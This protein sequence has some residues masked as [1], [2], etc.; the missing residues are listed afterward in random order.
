ML[1]LAAHDDD[2]ATQMMRLVVIHSIVAGVVEIGEGLPHRM[3]W[4][5][6]AWVQDE[7]AEAMIGARDSC[8]QTWT[9]QLVVLENV[10]VL[11]L[12]VAMMV[13]QMLP[14]WTV[15]R[16][17]SGFDVVCLWLQ[18]EHREP[19]TAVR[20]P[21]PPALREQPSELIHDEPAPCPPAR[22]CSVSHQQH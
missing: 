9:V 5:V 15:L 17:D 3:R 6:M 16:V 22:D 2:R 18:V 4:F 21:W 11:L 10:V 12:P 1:M 7:L 13:A 20:R 19:R 8:G 14:D